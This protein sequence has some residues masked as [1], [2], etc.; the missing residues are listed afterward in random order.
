MVSLFGVITHTNQH[1][2]GKVIVMTQA[3]GSFKTP[4]R[5]LDLRSK[6]V[7]LGFDV[8][9]VPEYSKRTLPS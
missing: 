8:K 1:D 6:A 2:F 9:D 7:N 3:T 5:I 4:W